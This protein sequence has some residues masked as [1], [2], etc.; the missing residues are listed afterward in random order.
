M[1]GR[2]KTLCLKRENLNKHAG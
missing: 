1:L 2:P